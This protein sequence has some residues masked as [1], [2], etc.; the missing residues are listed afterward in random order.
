MRFAWSVL[1]LLMV[2]ALKLDAGEPAA[3]LWRVSIV[4]LA[5]ANAADIHTS[6]DKRELN[7]VLASRSPVFGR[8]AALIK[9]GILGGVCGVEYLLTRRRPS[10]RLYR[11]LTLINF[12]GAAANGVVAYRN[13]T[14]PGAPR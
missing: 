5:A 4:S 8:D 10:S 14:L 2:S 6:W 11:A 9:M 7:P 13:S 1:V 12:G 3:R